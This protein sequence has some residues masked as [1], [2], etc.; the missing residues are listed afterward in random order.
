MKEIQKK[1]CTRK[2]FNG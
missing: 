1:L 2:H